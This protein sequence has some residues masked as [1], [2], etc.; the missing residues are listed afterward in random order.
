M[1]LFLT[2]LLFPCL[3]LAKDPFPS[4]ISYT[5]QGNEVV[6][7]LTGTAVRKKLLFTIYRVGGYLQQGVEKSAASYQNPEVPKQIRLF[8]LRSI[9][10]EMARKSFTKALEKVHGERFGPEMHKKVE[11]L[12]VLFQEGVKKGDLFD[13]RQ[14]SNG[15]V[16]IYVNG[17]K[18]FTL[19][20]VTLAEFIL[21]IWIGDNSIV[22]RD[23]LLGLE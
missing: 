1:K 6:L 20:D 13:F 16:D 12:L 7:E 22:N 4:S 3:L 17:K 5:D 9:P 19:E 8:W 18:Q 2:F 23:K 15:S 21:D 10:G 14:L 11:G